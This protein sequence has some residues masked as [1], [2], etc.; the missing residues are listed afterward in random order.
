MDL[1]AISLYL[2][3]EMASV[4]RVTDDE[5]S[6]L[7]RPDVTHDGE[8][9]DRPPPECKRWFRKHVSQEFIQ[10]LK[11]HDDTPRSSDTVRVSCTPGGGTTS[12]N[13]GGSGATRLG[14]ASMDTMP[15]LRVGPDP[16]SRDIEHDLLRGSC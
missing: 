9:S 10:M 3:R 14:D 11:N 7:V 6:K 16:A 4:A 13:N 2:A 5:M 12:G 8:V 1:C 15:K